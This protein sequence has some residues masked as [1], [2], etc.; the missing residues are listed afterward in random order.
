MFSIDTTS[1]DKYYIILKNGKEFAKVNKTN[2]LEDVKKYFGITTLK[3][4]SV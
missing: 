2:K 3:E 4:V 1:N